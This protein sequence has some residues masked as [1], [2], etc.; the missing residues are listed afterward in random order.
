MNG[1][2]IKFR[3]WGWIDMAHTQKGWKYFSLEDALCSY[4]C[5]NENTSMLGREDDTEP[6]QFTGILDKNGKEIY[7][8]DILDI[9]EV[10]AGDLEPTL[11][12]EEIKFK[13]GQF[14]F[15]SFSLYESIAYGESEKIIGEI[16]GNIHENSQF[17]K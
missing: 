14:C 9:Q 8:G 3:V 15:G 5:G 2:H 16:I 1:R 4:D 13:H 6:Q 12:T 11:R 10:I 7:E 17:L